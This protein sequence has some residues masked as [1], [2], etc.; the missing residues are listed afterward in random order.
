MGPIIRK[1]DVIH[2][3]GSARYIAMLAGKDRATATG[4]IAG[5]SVKFGRV[6]P[7][8]SMWMD[9]LFGKQTDRQS[10]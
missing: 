5:I 9:K 6:I 4:N 3:I 7:D 10:Y 8:I 1:H 2:E